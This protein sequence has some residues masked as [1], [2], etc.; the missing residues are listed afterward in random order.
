MCTKAS[1]LDALWGT[2]PCTAIEDTGCSPSMAVD[3]TLR[4]NKVVSSCV[5]HK[6]SYLQWLESVINK[7]IDIVNSLFKTKSAYLR[8]FMAAVVK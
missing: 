1:S 7:A 6:N 5:L 4:V 8:R 2:G 3:N